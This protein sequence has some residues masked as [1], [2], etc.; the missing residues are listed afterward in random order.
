MAARNSS[1]AKDR[2]LEQRVEAIEA[3]LVQ[4]RGA[5]QGI[6]TVSPDGWRRAIEKYAGDEDLQ[7]IFKEA[8]KLREADRK[9]ARRPRAAVRK[10]QK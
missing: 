3:E 9:R 10:P 8:M 4:L 6:S 2:S 5:F 7:S 1:S